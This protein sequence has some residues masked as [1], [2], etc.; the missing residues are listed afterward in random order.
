MKRKGD[1]AYCIA[2]IGFTVLFTIPTYLR[3]ESIVLMFMQFSLS[4]IVANVASLIESNRW[5]HDE[6]LRPEDKIKLSCFSG[7]SAKRKRE[8]KNMFERRECEI[9]RQRFDKLK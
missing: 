8:N 4:L 5:T 7:I 9:W 1:L 3:I 2:L 6:L